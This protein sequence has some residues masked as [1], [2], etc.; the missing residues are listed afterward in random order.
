V[1]KTDKKNKNGRKYEY[2]GLQKAGQLS[3]KTLNEI[4]SL[5]GEDSTFQSS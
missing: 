2:K 5:P 1:K 3:K 4:T